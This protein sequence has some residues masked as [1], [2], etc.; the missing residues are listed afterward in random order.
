MYDKQSTDLDDNVKETLEDFLNSDY[1]TQKNLLEKISP[2]VLDRIEK[3]KKRLGDKIH[4]EDEM[5]KAIETAERIQRERRAELDKF[6]TVVDSASKPTTEDAQ[7]LFSE[8]RKNHVSHSHSIIKSDEQFNKEVEEELDREAKLYTAEFIKQNPAIID[9]IIEADQRGDPN[10]EKEIETLINDKLEKQIST[11]DEQC[12]IE[13]RKCMDLDDMLSNLSKLE[14]IYPPSSFESLGVKKMSERYKIK[15]A[16]ESLNYGPPKKL[17]NTS[18]PE[19][20]SESIASNNSGKS[21]KFF[22][23]SSILAHIHRF[24]D[25]SRTCGRIL[26]TSPHLHVRI[27][28]KQFRFRRAFR[29]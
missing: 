25:P 21:F 22:G 11:L 8:Y 6:Q 29:F 20:R 5:R 4:D 19:R 13:H 9:T 17:Y 18:S 14:D 15:E 16:A 23:G 1:D 26:E 3:G 7:K 12:V 28:T 10:K 24:E 2:G 27:R